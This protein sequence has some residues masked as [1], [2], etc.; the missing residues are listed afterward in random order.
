LARR[1]VVLFD[2]RTP[3]E[4]AVSRIGGAISI[5]PEMTP[6][7]WRQSYGATTIGKR[8][9]FYCAVGLRSAR[10]AAPLGHANLRGGIFRWSRDGH[11][12]VNDTGPTRQVHPFNERWGR[13]LR[14][15]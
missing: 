10:L 2:V 4:Q 15:V 7:A 9:V 3:A 8:V 11:A 12:L 14:R 6:A 5:S 1:D 13:L